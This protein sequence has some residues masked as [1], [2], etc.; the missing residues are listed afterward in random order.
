MVGRGGFGGL[1]GFGAI[2]VQ[3]IDYI[4]EDLP[5]LFLGIMKKTTNFRGDMTLNIHG[6]ITGV[7]RAANCK[8]VNSVN[9]TSNITN[10]Q[11]CASFV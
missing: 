4:L 2:F 8:P 7:V 5:C 6:I 3:K 10:K 11:L 9:C 1:Q